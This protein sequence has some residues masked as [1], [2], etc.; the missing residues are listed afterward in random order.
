MHSK[1]NSLTLLSLLSLSLAAPAPVP[2]PLPQ[3]VTPIQE[4]Q[5]ISGLFNGLNGLLSDVN[6][7]VAAGNPSALL[8]ALGDIKPIA[9]PTDIPNA[10]AEE[11]AIWASE[12][13]TDFFGAVATQVANGLILDNTFSAALTGA[14]PAGENSVINNNL[15]PAM[16][17]Y[18]KKASIDAPYTLSEAALRQALFIPPGFTYGKK[19][20][21]LFVPGT[22]A[23]GGSN[24]GPNL[25]KLLTGKDYADP[26][27]LNIPNAMLGDAQTNSE[28]IAYAIHYLSSI[29][30]QKKISII[31]WSQG[32]L[33]TQWVLKFWP[34][35][36]III[37][38]FLAISPDFKGTVLAN[39]LCLSPNT[40]LALNPLCPASVIQQ[41]ATSKFIAAMRS[42]DGSSAYV[43]TT[44]FYSALFDEIVQPQSGPNASAFLS[45]VRG[46]GVSN[47]E[48]Q[49][50]CAGQ[51]GSGFYDH[52]GVLFHPLTWAL[53]VDALMYGGVGKLE[54]INVKEVCGRLV[55][56]GLDLDD[57]LATLGLIPVAAVLL[58]ASQERRITEP[59][60]RKYAV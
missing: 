41:E 56:P 43:P 13:R 28:Y 55:A 23:Y 29:S 52:A 19:N 40:K 27:W 24:F 60:L 9:R 59:A 45:D 30:Q 17:I 3:D 57:V 53:V 20:P 51:P 32:S 12:A 48:V 33:D 5:L 46:V 37:R 35:T 42:N 50:V 54:R 2:V 38:S 44:T 25:R 8:S 39:A 14:L 34:S 18:P 7:A 1:I 16:T 10:L 21:V 26:V 47:N 22:G 4:R 58:A 31:A 6:S 49:S 11:S 36:R 15:P